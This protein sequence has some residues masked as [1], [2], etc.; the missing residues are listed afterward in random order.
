M[1]ASKGSSLFFFFDH[2]SANTLLSTHAPL[3]LL[4]RDIQS[5]LSLYLSNRFKDRFPS[6][7]EFM[8][9]ENLK[10]FG[11]SGRHFPSLV[12]AYPIRLNP[13]LSWLPST[14]CSVRQDD[15]GTVRDVLLPRIVSHTPQL[16]VDRCG[17]VVILYRTGADTYLYHRP[18]RR[19]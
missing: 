10:T 16:P 12:S 5:P 18:L 7:A 11:K 4:S 3:T 15:P 2:R 1:T 17:G 13:I 14:P 6:T 8:S 19:S 9:I